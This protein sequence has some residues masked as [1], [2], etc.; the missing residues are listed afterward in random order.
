MKQRRNFLSALIDFQSN[1][2]IRHKVGYRYN[3]L[4]VDFLKMMAEIASYAAEKYGSPEQY[5]TSRLTEDQSPINHTY[6]HLRQYQTGEPY[7]HFDNDPRYHLAAIA[8]NVMMEY[9]YHT[10][11]GHLLNPLVSPNNSL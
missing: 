8:Y 1:V 3:A 2:A 11:W 4:N 7:E 9:W 10:K 5:T 6:E